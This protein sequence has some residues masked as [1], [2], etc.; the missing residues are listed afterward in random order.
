[1]RG[2]FRIRSREDEQSDE[3]CQTPT[4]RADPRLGADYSSPKTSASA[5]RN[6][7]SRWFSSRSMN[8]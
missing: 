3:G 4:G 2:K 6:A 5:S 8:G 1:M 7:V